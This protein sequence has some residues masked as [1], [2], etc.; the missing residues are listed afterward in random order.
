MDVV[1]VGNVVTVWVDDVDVK[2]GRI[3]LT[4]IKE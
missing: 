4:M 2:R 1:S 3:A